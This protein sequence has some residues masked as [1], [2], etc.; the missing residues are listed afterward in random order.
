MEQRSRDL[1]VEGA[2]VL[3]VDDHPT[4]RLVLARQLAMLG[5]VAEICEGGDEALERFEPGVHELVVT[6]CEMPGMDGYTLTRAIRAEERKGGRPRTSIIAC[7]AH[8]AAEIAARCAEAGADAVLQK[9]VLLGDLAAALAANLPQA[10]GFDAAR[11][12]LVV[13]RDIR[14][15][16]EFLTHFRK[17]CVDDTARLRQAIDAGDRCEVTHLAHRIRGAARTVGAN[18]LAGAAELVEHAARVGDGRAYRGRSHVRTYIE[19]DPRRCRQRLIRP[20]PWKCSRRLRFGAASATC[21]SSSSRTM[22][23]SAGPWARC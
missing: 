10:R 14:V 12:A 19:G 2:R 1:G 8:P 7:S 4:N 11:V 15:Q 5:C 6:D 21:A 20:R 9:P 17:A 16:R 23:S 13:G 22:A 3:I 18:R